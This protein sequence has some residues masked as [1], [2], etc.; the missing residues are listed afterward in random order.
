LMMMLKEVERLW[1]KN[2]LAH[3]IELAIPI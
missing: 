1:R 3:Q 2:H